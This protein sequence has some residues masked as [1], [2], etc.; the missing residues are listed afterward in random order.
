M[1]TLLYRCVWSEISII[2]KQKIHFP[3]NLHG[4]TRVTTTKILRVTFT[5]SL[6]VADYVHDVISSCV[7]ALYAL[8]VLRA[9]GMDDAALQT[10]PIDHRQADLRLQGL[11]GVY[12]CN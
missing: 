8:R 11:V 2:S 12:Q 10:I 5:N 1:V 9:H 4:I 6:S 3:P 7:Q